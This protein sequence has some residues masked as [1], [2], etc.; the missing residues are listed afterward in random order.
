MDSLV[1]VT[2]NCN[3]RE[4]FR[5]KYL[6]VGEIEDILNASDSDEDCDEVAQIKKADQIDIVILPPDKVDALRDN[7]DVDED[8]QVQNDSNANIL[9]ETAGQVEVCFDID[10]GNRN[11]ESS[12]TGDEINEFKNEAPSIAPKFV[13]P[14]PKW[15]KRKYSFDKQPVD[16]TNESIVKVYEKIGNFILLRSYGHTCEYEILEITGSLSP[17]QLFELFFDDDVVE[18]IVNS[19]NKNAA[20]DRSTDFRT[21][22]DEIRKVMGILFVTGYHTLPTIRSYWS[23]NPSLGC[24]II[25]ATTRDRFVRVKNFFHV[26]DNHNI[27]TNDKFVKVTTLNDMMNKRFM[28]F[29]VFSHNLSIDEQ[30]IAYYG[31]HSCK[32]FIRGKPIRFGYKYWCLCSSNGYLYKLIPYA[33][34]SEKN[35]RMY[36]LGENVVLQLLS[37]VEKPNQHTITFDNFFTSFKLMCHLTTLGYFATGTVREN[38]TGNATI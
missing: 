33:G 4:M 29:A 11:D 6:T 35:N 32:M 25:K 17:I 36:S 13:A 14:K 21:N 16:L 26:C 23:N 30:M 15:S 8:I 27:D 22:Y 18:F 7:E 1:F 2:K 20:V 28:Q 12:K 31:R 19:T 10:N 38:R 24:P 9:I 5:K 3:F 37:V 34:A